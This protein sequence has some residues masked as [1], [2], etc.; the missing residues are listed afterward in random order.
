MFF[1]AYI[2]AIG[3]AVTALGTVA[4]SAGTLDDVK[5][6]GYLQCGV[7]TGLAGFS[8]PDEKGNWTGFDVDY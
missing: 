6:R 5:A 4:A 3:V 7:S 8:I 2:T 1:K